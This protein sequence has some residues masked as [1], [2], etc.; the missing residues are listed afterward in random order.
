MVK[1][2]SSFCWFYFIEKSL[3]W[4]T[5][6]EPTRL[7]SSWFACR[8]LLGFHS[9]E[10]FLSFQSIVRVTHF[11]TVHD[12]RNQCDEIQKY[13]ASRVA[14]REVFDQTCKTIEMLNKS[15]F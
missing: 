14:P 5:A 15:H 9:I 11:R 1:I 12:H 6:D 3:S 13:D 8:L 10:F 4:Q 7:H 2:I